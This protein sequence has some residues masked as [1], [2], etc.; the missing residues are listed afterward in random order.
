MG[1]VGGTG[2]FLLTRAFERGPAALL[3]P[4]NYLQLVGAAIIGFFLYHDLPDAFTWAGAAAIVASGLY[5]A[6]G[7]NRRRAR[8][9]TR[10]E[11]CV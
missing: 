5:I 9:A 4:F 10:G 7:E 2:H 11:K 3:A 8:E 1:A 6:Y